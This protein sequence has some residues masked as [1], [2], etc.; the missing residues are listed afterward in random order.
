MATT[1]TLPKKVLK[2]YLPNLIKN[3][4][5]AD[6]SVRESASEA[7]GALLKALGDK[8]I[9][10]NIADVE[11]IKQDKIKEYATKCVLLNAKG[12]PR[13]GAAAAAAATSAPVATKSA[14]PAKPTKVTT[15]TKPVIGGAK[16]PAAGTA[17]STS[18]SAPAKK[19]VKSSD[20]S[21]KAPA[22]PDEPD[23]HVS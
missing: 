2:L 10:P 20:D 8:I 1:A 22:L 17:K 23:L 6:P 18:A 3:L 15:A 5:E 13:G 7:L 9:L 16:K 12:E 21:K 11:Q 4:G 19:V 14:V